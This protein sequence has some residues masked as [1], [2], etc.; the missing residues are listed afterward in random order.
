MKLAALGL[1]LVSAVDLLAADQSH[2]IIVIKE[3][4]HAKV[5]GHRDEAVNALQNVAAHEMEPY[6]SAAYYHL[7]VM[8]LEAKGMKIALDDFSKVSW[9]EVKR[10]SEIRPKGTIT[11]GDLYWTIATRFEKEGNLKEAFEYYS[12][13]LEDYQGCVDRVH[14]DEEQRDIRR[15]QGE[16]VEETGVHYLGDAGNLHCSKRLAEAKLKT[17]VLQA[18]LRRAN[19]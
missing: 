15:T 11:L 13:A 9:D 8:H 12:R 5:E 2:A 3:A 17:D 7:G 14:D 19:K 6:R 16:W 18:D 10:L 4:L 1:L